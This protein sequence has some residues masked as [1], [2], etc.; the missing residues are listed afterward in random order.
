MSD[1]KLHSLK[2]ADIYNDLKDAI[3]CGKYLR[4]SFIP[5]EGE[6]MKIYSVS[7]TTVRKAVDLL[8]REKLVSVQRGRG[9]EV[10]SGLQQVRNSKIQIYHDVT[11]ISSEYLVEGE[12]VAMNSVIDIVPAD[13]D[14]ARYME[15]P[16]NTEVFQIRR[17]KIL[18]NSPFN[19]VIS[20]VPCDLAPGLERYSGQVFYLYQCLDENYHL[21]STSITETISADTAKFLTANLLGVSIGAPLLLTRRIAR[22]GDRV[23]E[24]TISYIRPDIY[25][26]SVSMKGGLNYA[27]G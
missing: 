21:I 18:G 16:E 11:G 6:L 2:Y 25:Q 12:S 27:N 24:Y 20:Y 9:T 1:K 14:T 10:I 8:Q 19:Y 7:R 22:H 13:T 4:G 3:L 15:L 5:S 23:M 26:I 17:L